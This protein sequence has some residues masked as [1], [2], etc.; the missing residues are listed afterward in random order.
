MTETPIQLIQEGICLG[1]EGKKRSGKTAHLVKDLCEFYDLGYKC[2]GNIPLTEEGKIRIPTY[3]M[4]DDDLLFDLEKMQSEDRSVY[5]YQ[6]DFKTKVYVAVDEIH[7]Y[8]DKRRSMTGVNIDCS[9]FIDQLG[10]FGVDFGW[11]DKP[12]RVDIRLDEGTDIIIKC[13]KFTNPELISSD[14]PMGVESFVYDY[15]DMD[16]AYSRNYRPKRERLMF[17][18]MKPY[19]SLYLTRQRIMPYFRRKGKQHPRQPNSEDKQQGVTPSNIVKEGDYKRRGTKAEE[20]AVIEFIKQKQ[21]VYHGSTK[22]ENDIL[23][24]SSPISDSLGGELFKTP[25]RDLEKAVVA[26]KCAGVPAKGRYVY[27]DRYGQMN[28]KQEYDYS[29]NRIPCY[30]LFNKADTQNWVWRRVSGSLTVY[31]KGW[32]SLAECVSGIL[33]DLK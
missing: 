18:E 2:Y 6:S 30:L 4:I 32:L 7:G 25:R 16:Y 15:Y 21:K 17:S 9:E 29:L 20:E 10:K 1:Y 27:V 22:E 26:V 33:G 8:L 24:H 13:R 12:R 3:E 19:L 28:I 31:D 23:I 5:P 11:S 14:N